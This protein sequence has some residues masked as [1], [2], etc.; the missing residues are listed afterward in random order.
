MLKYVKDAGRVLGQ[1]LEAY[2][3]G[4]VLI[5]ARDERKSCATSRML[6]RLYVRTEIADELL[7]PHLEPV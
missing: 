6:K 7:R 1:G 4:L 3:K 5:L 2:R